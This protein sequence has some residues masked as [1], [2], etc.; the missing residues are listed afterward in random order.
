ML[1]LCDGGEVEV[2]FMDWKPMG[3]FAVKNTSEEHF[4]ICVKVHMT[5]IQKRAPPCWSITALCSV[6]P[7]G[8]QSPCASLGCR[9]EP[10]RFMMSASS[11][12]PNSVT[13]ISWHSGDLFTGNCR[14]FGDLTGFVTCGGHFQEV[15]SADVLTAY[16]R[17]V[18]AF[19][20]C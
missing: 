14:Y 16:I 18:V 7:R 1:L 19:Y 4:G 3:V 8:W 5:F 20:L 13:D 11:S 10:L 6:A 2:C 9:Q 15:C 17:A 12:V